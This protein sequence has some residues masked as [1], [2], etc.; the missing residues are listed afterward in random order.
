VVF[1]ICDQCGHV[2][3]FSDSAIERRLKGWS[4]DNRFRLSAATVELHGQCARCDGVAVADAPAV[5]A[6]PAP[7]QAAA[8]PAR[9]AR[10]APAA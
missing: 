1:A 2:D 10:K 9:R 5:E 6:A 7:A 3:E 4:K 8:Q